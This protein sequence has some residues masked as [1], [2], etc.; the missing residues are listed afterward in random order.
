M[1]CSEISQKLEAID[2]FH[3]TFPSQKKSDPLR[4]RQLMPVN[5]TLIS[6]SAPPYALSIQRQPAK[7]P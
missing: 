1:Q 5:S 7:H 3:Q 4:K 6:N 2:R